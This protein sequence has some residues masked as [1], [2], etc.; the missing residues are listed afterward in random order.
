[1]S[2]LSIQQHIQ[3]FIMSFLTW[4]F[5]VLV[6]LPDYYQSW[7]FNNKFIICTLVTIL[8]VPFGSYLLKK[9]FDN[10]EYFKNSLW[11]ASYLTVPLFIFDVFYIIGYLG[12]KDLSFVAKYWY[13][14]FFY[15]SFWVQ[16]PLVGLLMEQNLNDKAQTT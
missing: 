16:F 5:F 9:L 12:E 1:M 2:S 11:L 7:S 15:F 10:Q 13:L 14:T 3:L 4:S 8:Y 6:G